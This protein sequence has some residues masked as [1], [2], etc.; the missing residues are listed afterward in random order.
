MRA[1][2]PP[3][4]TAVRRGLEAGKDWDAAGQMAHR[5]LSGDESAHVL[6]LVAEVQG[7]YRRMRGL[8]DVPYSELKVTT[9]MSRDRALNMPIAAAVVDGVQ[10]RLEDLAPVD[11]QGKRLPVGEYVGRSHRAAR[12]RQAGGRDRAADLRRVSRRVWRPDY[13]E[14]AEPRRDPMSSARW[15]DQNR[16]G[17]ADGW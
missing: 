9:A 13:R 16:H 4:H 15:P 3:V 1:P 8:D 17:P 11:V 10:V 2:P 14:P 12:D 6:E 7:R 5:F